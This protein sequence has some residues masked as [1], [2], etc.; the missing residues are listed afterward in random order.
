MQT[1]Q[2]II[3]IL[4]FKKEFKEDLLK[5]YDTLTDDQ[6][7]SIE[8]IVFDLYDGLYE[9]RL[10]ENMQ[11][12]FEA[13]KKNEEKLD[14]EFYQR[15]RLQTEKQLQEEFSKTETTVDLSETR[16]ELQEILGQ[17]K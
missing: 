3:K 7:F 15:V 17:G 1:I 14:H 10:E 16:G 11:L 2:D 8:R 4:P 13:A 12:A 6:R 9:A 5:N